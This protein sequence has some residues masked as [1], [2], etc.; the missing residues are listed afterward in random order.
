MKKSHKLLLFLA[1]VCTLMMCCMMSASAATDET[2][3]SASIKNNKATITAFNADVASEN[4]EFNG[5]VSIP[6]TY[7]GYP[8]TTIGDSAFKG[9]TNITKMTIPDGVTRIGY[10]AFYGCTSLKSI[11][12]P[13]SVDFIGTNNFVKCPSLESIKVSADNNYYISV[14]DAILF[15]K[16]MTTLLRFPSAYKLTEYTVPDTVT[17]IY[18]YA[19]EGNST[20]EKLTMPDSIIDIGNSAFQNCTAL[21]CFTIPAGVSGISSGTFSGCTNLTEFYMPKSV[22]A[23]YANAFNG[24]KN[25]VHYIGNEEEFNEI[26]TQVSSFDKNT[27][28]HYIPAEGVINCSSSGFYTAESCDICAA[29]AQNN[30][31]SYVHELENNGWIY[32]FVT[33]TRV[34]DCKICDYYYS[35]DFKSVTIDDTTVYSKADG[36]GNFVVEKV[37]DETD[38]RYIQ[39]V[40]TTKEINSYYGVKDVYEIDLQ[41]N[42]GQSIPLNERVLVKIPLNTI[43]IYYDVYYIDSSNNY[44][45]LDSCVNNGY[46]EFQ[47]DKLGI[48][49]IVDVSHGVRFTEGVY[50]CRVWF[51]RVIIEGVNAEGDIVIPETL[52]GYPVGVISSLGSCE[53]ITSV[54]IPDSVTSI[55][56]YAFENCISI[57]SITIGSGVKTIGGEFVYNSVHGSIPSRA[58]DGCTSLKNIFVSEDNEAYSSENGILY[59]KDKS[60]LIKC[61]INNDITAFT[62]YSSLDRIVPFAFDGCKNLK[63]LEFI[64]YSSDFLIGCYAFANCTNLEN[65]KFDKYISQII[66]CAFADCTSLKTIVFPDNITQIGDAVIAGCTSLELVVLGSGLKTIGA[67]NFKNYSGILHYKG[68]EEQLKSM[69]SENT[70]SSE[71]EFHCTPVPVNSDHCLLPAYKNYSDDC[72]LCAEWINENE[73]RFHNYRY[74]SNNDATCTQNGTVT[75]ICVHCHGRYIREDYSSAIGHKFTK[76]VSNNDATCIMDGTKTAF[77]DNNCGESK[78]VRDDGTATYKHIYKNYVSNNDATCT[79]NGTKTAKCE[80]CEAKSTTTDFGSMLGHSYTSYVSNNDSTCLDDGTKTAVC[81]NGCGKTDTLVDVGSAKGHSYTNYISNEDATCTEDGTLTAV[82]ENGCGI[83]DTVTDVGSKK[84][85]SYTNYISN[86]DATCTEDGTK[87]AV[88]DN[89]CGETDTLVDKG[90]EKGHSYTNYISNEDA[91]CTEDGTKTAVCDN[92]CGETDTLVE[93][94][95]AKG[96]SYTNYV[97]DNNATCTEDGTETAKCDNNCGKTDTK[98]VSGTAKGHSFTVYY[99]DYNATCTD[100]GTKT[101]VCNNGCGESDTIADTGSAKGHSF[102][103]YQITTS[104]TCTKDG[105]KTAYCDNNCGE[106]KTAPV[107][108]LGH[109]YV[110]YVSNNDATCSADGTKTARCERCS[111]KDTI[112]DKGSKLSHADNNHDGKCDRCNTNTTVGCSCRC[113]KNDFIWK[114]LNFFYK[115]F[116]MNRYCACNKAHY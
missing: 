102:T 85:H 83:P 14:N 66:F 98:T 96:H 73:N 78:T 41:D 39:S 65:I 16:D 95:S 80:T 87:T 72:E 45:K 71:A 56:T 62:A 8:V 94:G 53:T 104:A 106:K 59:N 74:T 2:Y 114:F 34:E 27:T 82:C 77:C 60:V 23:L 113:H 25:T 54:V 26:T 50:N 67:S 103:N 32:N 40:E 48:Y 107:A 4:P 68:T 88:C 21:K 24:F 7:Q 9:V 101:A 33:M 110:N 108:K 42:E 29:W 11:V 81:D 28:I 57:E 111:S 52:G 47:T 61:P 58:F 1:L 20:L 49:V 43:R 105:V 63:S 75:G 35:E 91:T 3:F 116:K 31:A 30:A 46:I 70:F 37:T 19:F 84:G 99:S 89:G 100:D 76:Y 36:E 69:L 86:K 79:Q 17:W 55:N 38:E 109:S 92:G 115:L 6:E 64:T 93:T 97:Y 10:N 18:Y 112:A 15:N 22:T 90:S 12:I 51:G 13:A 5:E 44:T